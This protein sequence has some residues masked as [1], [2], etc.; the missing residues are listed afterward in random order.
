MNR[1]LVNLSGLFN[2]NQRGGGRT[3]ARRAALS[4]TEI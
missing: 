2:E 3:S 1:G 4:W